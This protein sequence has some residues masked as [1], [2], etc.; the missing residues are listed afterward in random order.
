MGFRKWLASKIDTPPTI[1]KM[2]GAEWGPNVDLKNQTPDPLVIYPA[3]IIGGQIV[4]ANRLRTSNRYLLA[5]QVYW[6]DERLYSAVELM[7]I[8]IQKSI[9]D[10]SIRTEVGE[11]FTNEEENA[12]KAAQKW[13]ID[14]ELPRLFYFYT[15]DLWKYGDAVD[16]I[17]F[18][19]SKGIRSEQRIF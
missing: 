6:K 5:D 3:S 16:T 10:C 18:N 13:A 2:G 17:T 7:A 14:I 9:G 15:I 12:V 8:M 11:T 19:G 4:E 1:S